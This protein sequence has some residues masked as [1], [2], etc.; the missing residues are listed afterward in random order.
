M[1]NYVIAAVILALGSTSV[2]AKQL[3]KDQLPEKIRTH[4]AK[5]HPKVTNLVITEE[6]HFGQDLYELDFVEELT[7]K[8]PDEKD[9][10]GQKL[11][12]QVA[13]EKTA[14]F[15]RTNGHFFIN[16]EKIEAFNIIPGVVIN[17]LKAAFPDYKITAAQ[18]IPNPNGP[19][20]EYEVVI[21]ATGGTW[22][23][24]IDNK[25]GIISKEN[26][27]AAP[28]ATAAPAAPAKPVAAPAPAKK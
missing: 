6:K 11:K 8:V 25:G 27:S 5:K 7:I 16:A 9:A 2:Q 26:V 4:F 19:F 3:T 13:Q 1:K 18:L 22:R 15:Y 23:V 14:V 20:E 17:A 24:S 28:A 21:N 10:K 12:E